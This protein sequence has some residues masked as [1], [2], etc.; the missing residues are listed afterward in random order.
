[1]ANQGLERFLRAQF[2]RERAQPLSHIV[3]RSSAAGSRGVDVETFPIPERISVEEIG[4]LAETILARAQ[5]D[6]DGSG[7]LQRYTLQLFEREGAKPVGRYPFRMRGEEDP[8]WDEPAGEEAPTSKGLLT[9]MMRHNE[10]T[11]RVMVQ[12]AG[13]LTGVMARRMESLENMV[14]KLVEQRQSDLEILERAL[15]QQH[16][17]DMTMLVTD[18]EEKR[19]DRMIQKVEMLLPAVLHKLTGHKLLPGDTD[20]NMILVKELVNSMSPEQIMRIRT[21]L[22]QEQQILLFELLQATRSPNG[23]NGTPS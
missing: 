4:S 12:S 2:S 9:Q 5:E 11:V 18:N 17:R 23:N 10:A 1:M 14:G 16:E 21:N 19:K 22:S 20:P 6:A 13:T 15:S 8:E 3:L 7:G